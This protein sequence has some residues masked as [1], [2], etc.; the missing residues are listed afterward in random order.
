MAPS[1]RDELLFRART[2]ISAYLSNRQAG[3]EHL[4]ELPVSWRVVSSPRWRTSSGR[5]PCENAKPGVRHFMFRASVTT[6]RSKRRKR[7]GPPSRSTRATMPPTRQRARARPRM[8]SPRRRPRRHSPKLARHVTDIGEESRT[9]AMA[10][11]SESSPWP[12]TTIAGWRLVSSSRNVSI[13][14]LASTSAS[15]GGKYGTIGN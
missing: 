14:W 5:V 10:P 3:A 7:R 1:F 2:D 9:S 13:Q 15:N 12:G 11:I 8:D 4:R 6:R